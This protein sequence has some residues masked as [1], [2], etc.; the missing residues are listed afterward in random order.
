MTRRAALLDRDGTIIYERHYLSDPDQVE[1]LPGAAAGLRALS[2][3]GYRLVVITNQSGISRGY[4]DH[5]RLAEIHARVADLLAQQGVT[6]D[7][8][9]VCPHL[10][11]AG[12]DCRKPRP[13]LVHQ[14]ARELGFDPTE[15]IAVGDKACDIDLG[16]GVGA[17]TF[18]VTTGYGQTTAKD[19]AL[20]PDFVV[21]DLARVA[22]QVERTLLHGR[23]NRER[24]S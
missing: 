24:R 1:L 4:F 5:A 17:T 13:G 7:G 18:L 3:L 20:Q 2:D 8:I 15:S 12:C 10:P 22:A 19:A 16:R 11:E 21:A 9:Y 14:A 6:L 23:A